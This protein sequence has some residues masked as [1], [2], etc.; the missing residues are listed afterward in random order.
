MLFKKKNCY[1]G[2]MA[3]ELLADNGDVFIYLSWLLI[4][5]FYI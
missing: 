3:Y 2:C 5:P 1:K 4:N